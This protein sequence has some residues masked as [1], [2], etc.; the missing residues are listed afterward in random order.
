MHVDR[1]KEKRGWNFSSTDNPVPA[2]GV[3]KGNSLGILTLI[4]PICA[5]LTSES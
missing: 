1:K 5:T 4:C 2:K 3:F